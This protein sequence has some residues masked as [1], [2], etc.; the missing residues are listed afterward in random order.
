MNVMKNNKMKMIFTTLLFSF[1]AK[2]FGQAT[3]TM[4]MKF[5]YT[6]CNV[7]PVSLSWQLKGDSNTIGSY[8][9]NNGLSASIVYS[10]I[11]ASTYSF[12]LSI[13]T[14][15]S[16]EMNNPNS[17]SS[18]VT[19]LEFLKKSKGFD[20]YVNGAYVYANEFYPNALK[21]NSLSSNVICA[22]AQ[23]NLTASPSGF[24][25]EV[26]RWQYS[27][28]NGNT[29]IDLP[30]TFNNRSNTSI[31]IQELLGDNHINFF[32]KQIYFGLKYAYHTDSPVSI[33]YSPCAPEVYSVNAPNP[34]CNE[35]PIPDVTIAFKRD[36]E[37]DELLKYLS[38][39]KD[40]DDTAIL[41]QYPMDIISLDGNL[42]YKTF[43]LKNL[44]RLQNGGTYKIKYQAFK[45]GINKGVQYSAP[46]SY[47]VPVPLKYAINNPIQPSCF[48]GND[49]SVE[50]QLLSGTA[51][52]HFYQ[53]GTA[54]TPTLENG[55][56]YLRG[57]S[58]KSGGYKIMV[59][60]IN[61][62]IEK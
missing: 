18:T 47:T 62:C 61:G 9:N 57:L 23:L 19:F 4:E 27:T 40:T 48:G 39:V 59:T 52:Y 1:V 21:T 33:T 56:Y 38:I 14:N 54:V 8:S 43:T 41:F 50:I 24:P 10:T 32:G 5:N 55:K 36:L 58:A 30:E 45:A 20:G 25:T 35:S 12:N 16:N 13:N 46:F 31:T 2:G 53:D 37:T 15:C 28:D 17:R 6:P 3:Y 60:D 11:S 26:Y 49:G 42:P 7:N 34:I 51:P 44:S 22:G 29:W